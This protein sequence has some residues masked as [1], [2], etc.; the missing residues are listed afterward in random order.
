MTVV[1]VGPA[2]GE[3]QEAGEN[4]FRSLPARV[5]VLPLRDSVTFPELVIPLNVGQPRSLELINDVLRGDRSIVLLG[6]RDPE[7]ETPGPDQLYS[8]GVLGSIARMVRGP[9]ARCACSSRAARGCA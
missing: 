7:M 1:D 6:G 9:T 4:G 8:V 2:T 5:G 3:A